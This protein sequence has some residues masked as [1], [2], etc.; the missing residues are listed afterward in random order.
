MT[1]L[2]I[3]NAVLVRLREDS[4]V[5]VESTDDPVVDLVK[6]YVNDAKR[7]VESA[8]TW[9]SLSSEWTFATVDG[10]D[11]YTINGGEHLDVID[12]IYRADGQELKPMQIQELRKRAL[13]DTGKK[14][15]PEYYAVSGRSADDYSVRVHP[16]PDA[17]HQ[18]YVYGY[19]RQADLALDGD[20][21]LIPAQPVIYLA[22]ALASRERGETGAQM[23][24]EIMGQAKQFL[25]DAIAKDATNSDLD[26][27]WT[28]V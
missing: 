2:D 13:R 16:K 10:T 5:T 25:T 27:I 20:V 18:Y 7:T 23:M 3:V 28:S 12:V 4:V 15:T 8:H 19:K 14:N 9:S 26:N 22:Y 11:T 17:S 6:A 21:L 1:Y 24:P